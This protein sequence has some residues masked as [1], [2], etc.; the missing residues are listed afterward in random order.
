MSVERAED[1]EGRKGFSLRDQ[2]DPNSEHCSGDGG[3]QMTENSGVQTMEN[4]GVQMTENSG[5]QKTE[6]SVQMMISSGE[7][8]IENSGEVTENSDVQMTENHGEQKIGEGGEQRTGCDVEQKTGSGEH[9]MGDGGNKHRTGDSGEQRTGCGGEH[10]KGCVWPPGHNQATTAGCCVSPAHSEVSGAECPSPCL[11]TRNSNGVNGREGR[12]TR[13]EGPDST[14][15]QAVVSQCTEVEYDNSAYDPCAS[16]SGDR[17][18]ERCV[19]VQKT[20]AVSESSTGTSDSGADDRGCENDNAG[21]KHATDSDDTTHRSDD[22]DTTDTEHEH[23]SGMAHAESVIGDDQHSLSGPHRRHQRARRQRQQA[24][25]PAAPPP[26]RLCLPPPVLAQWRAVGRQ[27]GVDNDDDIARILMRN[28]EDVIAGRPPRPPPRPHCRE[29]GEVLVPLP[30]GVCGPHQHSARLH[31][32]H[33]DPGRGG[34]TGGKGSS[35]G[36]CRD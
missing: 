13:N 24:A 26:H 11:M 8:M 20:G 7:Q 18:V 19:D 6:N 25:S 35:C 31:H 22:S 15:F 3:M 2:G 16:V 30:C 27:W 34:F 10:G 33:D 17:C 36:R 9:R 23:G 28:Y 1:K 4:S 32:P 14:M 29:C 5:E 12:I 21:D